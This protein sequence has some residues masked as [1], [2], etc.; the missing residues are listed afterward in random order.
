MSLEL[1][2]MHSTCHR[3]VYR[4]S[5]LGERKRSI[6]VVQLLPGHPDDVLECRLVQ[7]TVSSGFPY[8][9]LSYAWGSQRKRKCLNID[10]CCLPITDNLFDALIQLR[11]S[12]TSRWLWIDAVCIDQD[13]I[14]ELSRQVR[15]MSDIY[16]N[17][18][19]VIVWLGPTE[20]RWRCKCCILKISCKQV[21][22]R[23]IE[24]SDPLWLYLLHSE[25]FERSWVLQEVVYAQEITV[26]FGGTRIGWKVLAGFANYIQKYPH[27]LKNDPKCL[28][29]AKK[30]SYMDKWRRLDP[31][32]LRIEDIVFAALGSKCQ[33]PVDQ[34]YS[35]LSLAPR[36]DET[37]LFNPDYQLNIAQVQVGFTKAVIE[38]SG[39]LNILRYVDHPEYEII[40]PSWIPRWTKDQPHPL[41]VE[42]DPSIDQYPD[43]E[44]CRI[45]RYNMPSPVDGSC[46]SM[47]ILSVEGCFLTRIGC[48]GQTISC[49]TDSSG[50][51]RDRYTTINDNFIEDENEDERNLNL[52]HFNYYKLRASIPISL[53]DRR[54]FKQYLNNKRSNHVSPL[55]S[56][57]P[58]SFHPTKQPQNR[59]PTS[60]H[61][62]DNNLLALGISPKVYTSTIRCKLSFPVLRDIRD[63]RYQRPSA[64]DK[65]LSTTTPTNSSLPCLANRRKIA[66]TEAEIY[67]LVPGATRP[68]D[69]IAAFWSIRLLFVLRPL[70][71][72]PDGK[73]LWILIGPCE[74]EEKVWWEEWE[75]KGATERMEEI[76]IC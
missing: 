55:T 50:E 19:K 26:R 38:D 4:H 62:F 71:E 10:G 2:K 58:T 72:T 23:C 3:D 73:R 12:R 30:I 18:I 9:A 37:L 56:P 15:W 46:R 45:L 44:V 64:I 17:A 54:T 52:K 6:R 59:H 34:I 27:P 40:L 65:S 51:P 43:F 28:S 75:R 1:V 67:A 49:S 60:T 70:G 53:S 7:T 20:K 69:M 8:K 14:A 48:V 29:T 16:S 39:S 68:G 42:H 57:S 36:Q 61:P 21:R 74:I 32:R 47:D 13:N 24:S 22:N 35:V 41:P 11:Q 33:K 76:W 63:A 66:L 5:P 25:W 31:S